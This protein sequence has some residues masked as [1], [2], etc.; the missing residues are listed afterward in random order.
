MKWIVVAI[1][2]MAVPYTIVTLRYRKE[3]PAFQPYE[4]MRNRANVSRLLSAGYQRITIPAQRPAGRTG[5]PGGAVFQNAPGGLPE[6]LRATL[7]ET[8]RLPLE[9]T[10]VQ[11]AATANNL[12]PYAIELTCTLPDDRH[13]LGGAELYLQGDTLV[14]T[15]TL[16]R[17]GGDLLTR[18]RQAAVLL[19]IPAGTLRRG[20]HRVILTGERSSRTWKLEVR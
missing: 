12:S 5:I 1:L 11:A 18:A 19:T 8:P 4:D 13:Q 3:G 10:S 2:L 15:P 6:E 14:L 16:E 20:T 9:I 17:V 7:V